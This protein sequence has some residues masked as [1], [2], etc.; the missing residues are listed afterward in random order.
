MTTKDKDIRLA[1]LLKEYDSLRSEIL[2]HIT[3]H[4]QI[5]TLVLGSISFAVPVFVSQVGNINPQILVGVLYLLAIVYSIISIHAASLQYYIDVAG[6]Y[7]NTVLETEINNLVQQSKGKTPLLFWEAFTRGLRTKPNILFASVLGTVSVVLFMLLPA[8]TLL[9]ISE[10]LL[11]GLSKSYNAF[12]EIIVRMFGVFRLISW[13]FYI[14]S[15]FGWM[16]VVY[17]ELFIFKMVGNK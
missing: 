4:R 1:V 13:L 2:N 15:V 10:S 3:H 16:N 7:I 6:Y 5:L 14:I 12:S 17:N 8:G 9:V 11:Y